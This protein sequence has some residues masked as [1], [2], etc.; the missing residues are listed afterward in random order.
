MLVL[1]HR[2]LD[3]QQ[4]LR[5]LKKSH[6]TRSDVLGRNGDCVFAY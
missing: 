3:G 4:M 5:N 1:V 6:F 2:P